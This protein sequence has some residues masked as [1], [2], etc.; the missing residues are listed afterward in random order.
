MG[1]P[2]IC[3]LSCLTPVPQPC[4]QLSSSLSP[5]CIPEAADASEVFII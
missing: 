1:I 2:A 4:Q 3:D 5:S